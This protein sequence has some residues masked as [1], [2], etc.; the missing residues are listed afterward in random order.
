ML[1]GRGKWA[2]FFSFDQKIIDIIY[3]AEKKVLPYYKKVEE[4]VRFNQAKVLYAFKKGRV[5]EECFSPSTGYGYNDYGRDKLEEVFASIYNAEASLVRPHFV[6]GTHTLTSCF[7]GLLRP[8]DEF[9]LLTG[10]PYETLRRVIGI[11]GRNMVNSPGSLAEW[12]I[13]CKILDNGK[14]KGPDLDKLP[15]LVNKKTKLFYI[16]R[17]RG[18]DPLRKSLNIS[19]LRQI[20]K[21]A[22]E[23]CPEAIVF[24]D[25]C[26][27]EFVEYNEPTEVGAD[28][29]AG[30]LIKNPG[31]G[32]SPIGGY[33]VGKKK[34][35]NRIADRLT[36]PGL[37]GEVGANPIGYRSFF[38]G[39]FLAPHNVGESL[40]GSIVSAAVFEELGFNCDP[41]Y[42]DDRGDIVQVIELGNP[43]LLRK[44]CR[45]IQEVSP[46]N[47]HVVPQASP[48]AGY[49][50]DIIMAAGTFVQGASSEL[51]AD[52]PL[53]PPYHVF[54]QGGL[55]YEHYI[56]GLA[57][58]IKE[59]YRE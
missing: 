47:S 6:S 10:Q 8:G 42:F 12:G 48:M 30:S 32:L 59:I 34:L 14:E 24:V 25:N 4:V 9:V 57:N 5:G 39:I 40:K 22:K 2:S 55:T 16:Q 21:R 26:Y 52:A 17:S 29:V 1:L 18:Y 28:L 7:F 41:R 27:G 49:D 51:T 15:S 46:V 44:F 45:A 23:I 38:Q 37:A 35:I 11:N 13:T 53:R 54:I 3:D 36:A 19:E 31:G 58:V 20:I 50:N 56:I 43:D 33:V